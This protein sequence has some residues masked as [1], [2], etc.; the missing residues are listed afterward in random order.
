[1][2]KYKWATL[3]YFFILI[4]D[5]LG[6]AFQ[7]STLVFVF[8]PLLIPTILFLY[9]VDTRIKNKLYRVA[10]VVCFFGD[11]F[12]LGSEKL[13]FMLGLGSFLIAHVIFIKIVLNQLN[14]IS[15][16]RIVIAGL[17][18]IILLIS[19]LSLL[20]DSLKDLF[21]PVV[22]YGLTICSFGTIAFLNYLQKKDSRAM[23]MF[24]GSTVF[25]ASDLVLAINKFYFSALYL[26]VFVM[27]TYGIAQYLILKSME[28]KVGS[29]GFEPTTT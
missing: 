12:L 20:K 5:L 6:I 22:I 29:V 24:I 9:T 13:F 1:M 14:K 2:E 4:V 15:F 3:I 26:E 18:Y 17:P 7:N 10:L 27:L 28:V 11:V 19:I 23:F 8:K 21:F 25:I 16:K